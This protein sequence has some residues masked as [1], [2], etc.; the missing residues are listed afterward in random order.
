MGTLPLG[1]LTIGCLSTSVWRGLWTRKQWTMQALAGANRVVYVDPQE[2]FTYRWRS[3]RQRRTMPEATVP[4]GVRVVSPWPALPLGQDWRVARLCNAL[5]LRAQLGRL[6]ELRRPD[7]WWIYDPISAEV[8]FRNPAR[9]C[10]YD[11]VDRHAAYGGHR[12]LVDR[13]EAMLLSRADVVFVT[14]R[15]LVEH[16]RGAREVH[17]VSNGFDEDLFRDPLPTP[18][19]LV[20]IPRPRLGFIGGLAHWLDVEL[21]TS[22]ARARPEWSFVLV[23]PVADVRGVL[24]RARNIHWLG[25]CARHEVPAYIGGF[26]VGLVPFKETPLT[27]TVNPLKAYEYMAGGIPVVAGRLPELDHLPQVRQAP[28]TEGFI[29]AVEEALDEGVGEQQ[30]QRRR[31]A[32]EPFSLQRGFE[33]MCRILAEKLA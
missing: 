14:A 23:G 21:L 22:A 11:C 10:V 17:L 3:R 13:A 1:G 31:E 4:G 9:L 27:R 12:G 20:P 33:L 26:D 7:I 6:A 16:C 5:L 24:P 19:T 32:V 25:P 8:A 18:P 28:T 2:S 29:R 15:G 30:R